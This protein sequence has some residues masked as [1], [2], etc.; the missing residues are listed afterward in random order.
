MNHALLVT[1]AWCDVTNM[2]TNAV[3]LGSWHWTAVGR[4]RQCWVWVN[5]YESKLTS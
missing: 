2:L 1:L 5:S 3:L 4:S